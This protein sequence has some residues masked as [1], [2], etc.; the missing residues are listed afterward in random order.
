M[1]RFASL[2]LV[3][4]AAWAVA[5]GSSRADAFGLFYSKGCCNSCSGA[6]E[7][8]F[9]SLGTSHSCTS[10]SFIFAFLSAQ[11]AARR[12]PLADR[13]RAM[14]VPVLTCSVP[15]AFHR[16]AGGFPLGV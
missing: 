12:L 3:S 2:A 10:P 16:Q 9:F 6:T 14:T 7:A 1:N 13:D 4:V 11:A 8:T 5:A 15:A